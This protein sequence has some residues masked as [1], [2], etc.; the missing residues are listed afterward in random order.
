M[1]VQ[2]AVTALRRRPNLLGLDPDNNMR[3]MVDYL[4]STGKTQEEALDLLLTSL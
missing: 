1:D 3:R 2:R 4:Q